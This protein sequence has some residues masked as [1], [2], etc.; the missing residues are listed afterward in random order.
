MVQAMS[1]YHPH[2]IEEAEFGQG[3]RLWDATPGVCCAAFQLGA[4]EHTEGFDAYD[5]DTE[6][7]EAMA[8]QEAILGT[9]IDPGWPAADADPDAECAAWQAILPPSLA[10]RVAAWEDE[11]DYPF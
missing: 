10:S 5:Y 11:A 2:E 8:E 6:Y 9:V 4:C 7:D 3:P 1:Y